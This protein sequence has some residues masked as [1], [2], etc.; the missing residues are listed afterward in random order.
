MIHHANAESTG[1]TVRGAAGGL[2]STPKRDTQACLASNSHSGRGA[3]ARQGGD[4]PNGLFPGPS[5]R[6]SS[7]TPEQ[8]PPPMSPLPRSPLLSLA[9]GSAWSSAGGPSNARDFPTLELGPPANAPLHLSFRSPGNATL[10]GGSDRL[11][12]PA[13]SVNGQP[14]RSRKGAVRWGSWNRGEIE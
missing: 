9:Y 13:H 3:T 10:S 5:S 2:P 12:A 4:S 8:E 11:G 14:S 6:G 1:A 7:L